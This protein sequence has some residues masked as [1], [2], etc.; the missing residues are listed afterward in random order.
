MAHALVGYDPQTERLSYRHEIPRSK[1]KDVLGL[2]QLDRDDPGAIAA[3]ALDMSK[4]K[5]IWRITGETDGDC[6]LDYF[7]ESRS[8]PPA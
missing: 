7:L 3:Y 1:M 5:E 4:V 2:I 8:L 6:S